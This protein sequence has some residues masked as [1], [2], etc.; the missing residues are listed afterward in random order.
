MYQV[1][2][3][4]KILTTAMLSFL[5]LGKALVGGRVDWQIAQIQRIL[6]AAKALGT[7]KWCSLFILTTGVALIQLPRGEVKAGSW[8]VELGGY[9]SAVVG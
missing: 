5:I 1:T 9:I 8:G 2:Y 7:T 3:Q 6:Q 4:L